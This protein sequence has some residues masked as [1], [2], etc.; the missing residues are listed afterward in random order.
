ME[1]V[2]KHRKITITQS[3]TK[4]QTRAFIINQSNIGQLLYK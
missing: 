1:E 3:F 4:L 2:S